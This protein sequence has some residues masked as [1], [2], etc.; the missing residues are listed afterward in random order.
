MLQR[1]ICCIQRF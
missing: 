1:V